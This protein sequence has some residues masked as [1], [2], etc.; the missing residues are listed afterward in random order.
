MTLPKK[1]SRSILVNEH[2]YRWMV[3]VDED[4]QCLYPP[5]TDPHSLIVEDTANPGKI[6]RVSFP[7]PVKEEAWGLAITPKVVASIIKQATRKGWPSNT[8]QEKYWLDNTLLNENEW[9]ETFS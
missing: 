7:L 9:K 4:L 8:I 3:S 5:A 2:Q 6:L 1:R